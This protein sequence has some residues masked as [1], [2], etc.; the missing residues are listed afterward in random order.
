ML[1]KPLLYVDF[2]VYDRTPLTQTSGLIKMR[3]DFD[4][5]GGENSRSVAPRRMKNYIHYNSTDFLRRVSRP[6]TN[7]LS[8]II[9]HSVY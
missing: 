9:F 4:K 8:Q 3:F 6:P 2:F 1:E 7:A 5:L